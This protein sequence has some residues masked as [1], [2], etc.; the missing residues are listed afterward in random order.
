MTELQTLAI[1]VL[2]FGYR[3][4][5]LRCLILPEHRLQRC[6][7]DRLSNREPL[8]FGRADPIVCEPDCAS[9]NSDSGPLPA[10]IVALMF[11]Q[12]T[13]AKRTQSIIRH[14]PR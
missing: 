14:C 11:P 2:S 8:D 13:F 4:C 10:E 9:A 12:D 5:G 7:C 6:N 1:G 3:A